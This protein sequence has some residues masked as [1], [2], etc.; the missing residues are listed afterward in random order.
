[1]T[2]CYVCVS[3]SSEI[4][5]GSTA[6]AADAVAEKVSR[7][8]RGRTP[9]PA[10]V[11]VVETVTVTEVE[12]IKEAVFIEE[13]SVQELVA[14]VVELSV[15][16]PVIEEVVEIVEVQIIEPVIVPVAV[17]EPIPV[18]QE[19]PIVSA[20]KAFL[21][22]GKWE[23]PVESSSFQFGS[24]G[25]YSTDD[26]MSVPAPWGG[27]V[28]ENEQQIQSDTIAAVWG[29]NGSSNIDTS[30]SSSSG[31]SPMSS[32]FPAPKGLGS[33]SSEGSPSA[34]S[35]SHQ[36]ARYDQQKPSAPP[37]LEITKPLARQD[38]RSTAPGQS[39]TR[40][41]HE[42][43]P[44]QQ[45]LQQ[46]QQ[47]QQYQQPQY[48]QQAPAA[49]PAA[50]R[51]QPAAPSSML[52]GYAPGFESQYQQ[53]SYGHVA[54][55]VAPPATGSPVAST[56]AVS[57]QGQGIAPGAPQALQYGPPPGMP[58]HYNVP[59]YGSPYYGSQYFYGQPLIPNHYY[60]QGRG[61]YQTNRYGSDPY[62]PGGQYPNLYH[63]GG[64]FPDQGMPM[65]QHPSMSQQ[66]QVQSG[67]AAAPGA[68]SA[69]G[70]GKQQKEK[71]QIIPQQQDPNQGYGYNPYNSRDAQ[72]QQY[73]GW[74]APMMGFP[75]GSP[76]GAGG[77]QG[78]SQP[79]QQQQQ[80]QQQQS[81]Q[82]QRPSSSGYGGPSG[83]GQQGQGQQS[84][85]RGPGVP[86]ASGPPSGG[87]AGQ[88]W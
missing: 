59:Y 2:T 58:N 75:G 70:Q 71:V 14:E 85:S 55:A 62:A 16:E 40:G 76:T 65:Q 39:Q 86:N 67:A 79:P 38:S 5:E 78:F 72:W 34:A 31:P 66:T 84:F 82:G 50:A 43:N 32:L 29:A 26:S 81:G 80:Q 12:E 37:G 3:Q 73:Q 77:P 8:S 88:H 19:I 64:G 87:S 17:I 11:A 1:M 56:G 36:N 42:T 74:N 61:D 68:A 83:Q 47:Q 4:V 46:Q 53:T 6:V 54:P 24:F 30:A 25:N 10:A 41:K 22:M 20:P 44:Q 49:A 33:V 69:S 18:V 9:G 57:T 52:Y 21:K 48:Q 60:N 63:Q 15:V 35:G 13:E 27:A 45:Q 7:R 28:A 23:A 51:G